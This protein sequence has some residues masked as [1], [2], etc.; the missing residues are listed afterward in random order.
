MASILTFTSMIFI[1][2]VENG[3]VSFYKRFEVMSAFGTCGLS[4]GITGDVNDMS[5]GVLMVLMLIG[6]V[7]L[8]SFI[9]MIGGRRE[10][11]KFHY[12]KN[13]Y[14]LVDC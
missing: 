4:L 2:V 9:I 7:G 3:K 11:D 13:A 8:I 6:R 10:P 12:L 5:K 14:K 1:L